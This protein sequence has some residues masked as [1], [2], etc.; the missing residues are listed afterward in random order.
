MSESSQAPVLNNIFHA[1]PQELEVMSYLTSIIVYSHK[2]KSS[3]CHF[4]D[5]R[6]SVLGFRIYIRIELQAPVAQLK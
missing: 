5:M 4:N 3:K 1:Q 6:F 2:T